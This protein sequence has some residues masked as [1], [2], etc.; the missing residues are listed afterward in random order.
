MTK[1]QDGRSLSWRVV[2]PF[3]LG[4][5]FLYAALLSILAGS[6]FTRSVLGGLIWAAIFIP[7][8]LWVN[9][10]LDHSVRAKRG[11]GSDGGRVVIRRV[12]V[13]WSSDQVLDAV[14]IA[15]ERLPHA[16]VVSSE[17]DELHIRVGM[18]LR[19]WGERLHV[20]LRPLEAGT[21]VHVTSRPLLGSTLFDYG[22]GEENV[23][24]IIDCLDDVAS[25]R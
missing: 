12:N 22:K 25:R 14:R 15:A 10:A 18:S 5:A 7:V 4:T 19:S 21:L 23:Q 2:L 20:A 16:K 11:L 24:H 9:R 8:F 6:P 1:R 13:W 17:K 3:F